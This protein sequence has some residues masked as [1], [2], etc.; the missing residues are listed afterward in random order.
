MIK[1]EGPAGQAKERLAH[2]VEQQRACE[3][4][5]KAVSSRILSVS[6]DPNPRKEREALANRI[7]T[8]Q[9]A[10]QR[11]QAAVAKLGQDAATAAAQLAGATAAQTEA[12]RDATAARALLDS[13]L[14]SAGFANTEELTKAA[15]DAHKQSQL[16]STIRDSRRHEPPFCV[17]FSK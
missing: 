4:E 8:L 9:A 17:G 11:A 14:G 15:R 7:T 12:Q 2:F 10:A 5:L 1:A 16:E 13:A 3:E 6:T